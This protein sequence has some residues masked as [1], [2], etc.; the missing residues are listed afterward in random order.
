MI[1]KWTRWTSKYSHRQRIFSYIINRDFCAISEQCILYWSKWNFS[2]KIFGISLICNQFLLKFSEITTANGQKLLATEFLLLRSKNFT[3]NPFLSFDFCSVR[4]R[5]KNHALQKY[6]CNPLQFRF[7]QRS[8]RPK[9]ILPPD[10]CFDEALQTTVS[11]IMS[12]DEVCVK[13]TNLTYLTVRI[14]L[15]VLV[16]SLFK[17]HTTVKLN[18]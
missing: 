6:A 10:I 18:I 14:K 7:Y 13:L 1:I 12:C 2:V 4:Y 15:P 5:D 9:N 16:I 8:S 17:G 3:F 11:G